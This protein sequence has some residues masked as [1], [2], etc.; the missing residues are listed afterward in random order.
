MYQIQTSLHSLSSN[1]EW[2]QITICMSSYNSRGEALA[3]QLNWWWTCN[4]PFS[5]FY[6]FT[7]ILQFSTCNL[8]MIV[9]LNYFV[10]AP[11][12]RICSGGP[13]S[14]DSSSPCALENNR[15]ISDKVDAGDE[16]SDR[17][18][19]MW[20]VVKK[21]T[22]SLG[23]NGKIRRLR[24]QKAFKTVNLIVLRKRRSKSFYHTTI[25]ITIP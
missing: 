13:P 5:G 17:L 1:I 8:F 18:L 23:E 3:S 20:M 21:H 2:Q 25:I 24:L 7:L 16:D 22:S 12:L 9:D 10:V 4:L 19:I 6:I 15:D 14:L 11:W